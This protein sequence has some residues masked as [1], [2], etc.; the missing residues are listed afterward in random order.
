ME[1]ESGPDKPENEEQEEGMHPDHQPA[2]CG[3]IFLKFVGGAVVL[4]IVAIALVFGVCFLGS[5]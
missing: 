2:G 3:S 1:H 4:L 5:G